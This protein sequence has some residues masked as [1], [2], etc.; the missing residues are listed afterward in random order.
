MALH[1]RALYVTST[2]TDTASP[3][4]ASFFQNWLNTPDGREGWASYF[5][6][7]G[8]VVYLTDQAQRG[9]SPWLPNSTDAFTTFSTTVES[10]I[11]T[12]PEKVKP[13]PYPQA[14]LHTQWPGSGLAGDPIFD[15][16]YATQVQLQANNTLSAIYN[17]RSY[18]ALLDRIGSPGVILITHSQSGPFGWQIGDS[19]PDLVKGIVA[20]E[21]STRPFV[22]YIGPPFQPGY[23]P[24]FP[25]N[26]YGITTLPLHYDPPI[27]SNPSLLHRVHV[28]RANKNVAPCILQA[29]PARQ[30]PHLARIPVLH[31]QSESSYHSVFDYC[32]AAYM[33]QAGVSVDFVQLGDVGIRGNGHFIFLEENNLVV[34]GE[35]V[36]PW[37]EKVGG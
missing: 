37:L 16:F 31:I 3:T 36:L 29:K 15:A 21:P 20:M 24:A 35:V 6:R 26:T 12:A 22:N 2:K 18:V 34:A 1:R 30:L 28:P 32:T 7:H 4:H 13:L 11:F 19:R 14:A 27:G 9:R 5:L 23:M 33:R 8:Y 17:N 25:N 10:D